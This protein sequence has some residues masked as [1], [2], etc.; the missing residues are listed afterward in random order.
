MRK[1]DWK[2]LMRINYSGKLIHTLGFSRKAQ[3]RELYPVCFSLL[4]LLHLFPEKNTAV[5]MNTTTSIGRNP[6]NHK[7][8]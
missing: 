3:Y 1:P 7:T 2:L 8:R 6:F 4:F 5:T